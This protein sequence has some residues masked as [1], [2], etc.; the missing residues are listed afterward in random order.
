[1][2]VYQNQKHADAGAINPGAKQLVVVAPREKRGDVLAALGAESWAER[3]PE[4]A[5]SMHFESRKQFD[6][7]LIAMPKLST[8]GHDAVIE[9]FFARDALLFFGDDAAVLKRLCEELEKDPDGP[10]PFG[11]VFPLFLALLCENDAALLQR[12]EQE[13]SSLEDEI[14]DDRQKNYTKTI[15][16]LRKKLLKLKRF[17]ESLDDIYDDLEQN[18]NGLL[19]E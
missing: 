14:A 5:E 17:Y 12:I 16:S 3:A 10:P 8:H 1:M 15:S 9:V 13:I 19:S 11:D 6:Y 18:R 2:V 4:L 7:L